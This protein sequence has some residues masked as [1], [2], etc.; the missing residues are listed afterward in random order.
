MA[1]FPQAAVRR[2]I[3]GSGASGHGIGPVVLC[4]IFLRWLRFAQRG[5]ALLAAADE[6]VEGQAIAPRFG[7]DQAARS[8]R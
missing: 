8:G 6:E 5:I 2:A 7:D 1:K 3:R 4:A